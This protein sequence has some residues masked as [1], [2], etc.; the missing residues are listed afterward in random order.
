M[1]SLTWVYVISLSIVSGAGMFA[2]FVGDRIHP[3]KGGDLGQEPPTEA[4]V[5]TAIMSAAELAKRRKQATAEERALKT[6]SSPPPP[7]EP[8]APVP[9]VSKEVPVKE[10]ASSTEQTEE[11]GNV[12]G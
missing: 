11:P 6:A 7:P 9:V 8:S 12:L 10:E 5:N 2:A 3:I 1:V 4:Q